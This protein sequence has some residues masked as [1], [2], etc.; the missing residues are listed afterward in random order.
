MIDTS[1]R[2]SALILDISGDWAS[3]RWDVYQEGQ[4]SLAVRKI[5]TSSADPAM[6]AQWETE[7]VER[8]GALAARPADASIRGD[9]LSRIG[10]AL[11]D[12][13]MPESIKARIRGF[14]AGHLVFIMDEALA[15][16]PWELFH[17]GSDFL[18]QR[19]SI[20]RMIRSTG[21]VS[22][23]A[24][25]RPGE[26][27]NILMLA[28]PTGDLPGADREIQ[29]IRGA[30]RSFASQVG[31]RI[32]VQRILR[33]FVMENL[34]D[35][36][37]VHYSGHAR[38]KPD[39]P[40]GTGWLLSDGVF[41]GADLQ[42]LSGSDKGMPLLVFAN[43]CSS[44]RAGV[45]AGARRLTSCNLS[46]AFLLSGVRHFIGTIADVP[47]DMA[48]E[49]ASHF[50][51]FLFQGESAGG[52]LLRARQETARK[53]PQHP[54]CW[55]A[56]ALYGDPRLPLFGPQSE[57]SLS[58][59]GS[60]KTKIA[61]KEP[62]K[63]CA[64]CQ[65]VIISQIE[66]ASHIC[67]D[68]GL[69]ICNKCW[70]S[71]GITSYPA[72]SGGALR[73]EPSGKEGRNVREEKQSRCAQCGRAIPR[74][75][76]DTHP[77]AEESCDE[78]LCGRC[79]RWLDRRYCK[80]H[81][82][83]W[84]ERLARTQAQRQS[85]AILLLVDRAEA[86]R[87]EAAYY[88]ETLERLRRCGSVSIE[89][90]KYSLSV[91]D[92]RELTQEKEL[93]ALLERVS[94][95]EEI[96]SLCPRNR[97]IEAP[98]KTSGLWGKGESLYLRLDILS[99]LEKHVFPG[100][101]TMPL[102]S[103]MVTA[104]CDQLSRK[105][106]SSNQF[107]LHALASVTGWDE[108]ARKLA[109]GETDAASRSASRWA[110]MLVDLENDDVVLSPEYSR[111]AAIADLLRPSPR[112]A[113]A[114]RVEAHIRETLAGADDYISEATLAGQFNTTHDQVRSVFRSL[115]RSGEYAV[116]EIKGVGL[117]IQKKYDS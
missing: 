115:E 105:A 57:P 106:S 35:Y 62:S 66:G 38:F 73:Q 69:P 80:T 65:N 22:V 45:D 72:A 84:S 42:K 116:K 75:S 108:V 52:A 56:F 110:I 90:S 27:Q 109:S 32:K 20:G 53:F 96:Q 103:A 68:T 117:I 100:Y 91:A 94:D 79:W 8:L 83:P 63:R 54:P 26:K 2:L 101:D 29:I 64:I 77:C 70:A 33:Q 97:S 10:R 36:D 47:D 31:L 13:L 50:Y 25:R 21:A 43:A 95:R 12:H 85:G 11:W 48:A 5:E 7:I 59:T 60:A 107:I 55:L 37:V 17:D 41:S 39:D 16:I 113:I 93:Q 98:F 18:G 51:R 61:A 104:R 87:R 76:R 19:F 23:A 44:G 114:A 30:L 24:A 86:G 46:S 3:S 67:E 1:S 89:D 74:S 102:S 34:R 4:P 58:A 28:D 112:I 14:N 88:N 81:S 15:G 6:I 92:I 9:H 78:P 99:D 49:V 111:F 82:L 40:A 71:K